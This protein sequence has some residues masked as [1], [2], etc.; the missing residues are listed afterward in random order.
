MIEIT[1]EPLDVTQA[2][3]RLRSIDAGACVV[4]AGTTRRL[5]NGQET[6]ELTYECYPELAH[7]VLEELVAEAKKRWTLIEC[8]VWHRI[9]VV[10]LG[11]ASVLVGATS[12]HREAAFEAARW[13]IDTLKERAPIWKQEHWADGSREWIHPGIPAKVARPVGVQDVD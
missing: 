2:Y 1:N 6:V 10:P 8:L 7:K 11:E 3:E 4:F 13:L 9:G 5:T 12:A